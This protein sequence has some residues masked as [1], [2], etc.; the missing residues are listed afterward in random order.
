MTKTK[1][2]VIG[3]K[4]NLILET[5]KGNLR[6]KLWINKNIINMTYHKKICR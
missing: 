1:L 2:G 3:K 4:Y 6:F 5:F